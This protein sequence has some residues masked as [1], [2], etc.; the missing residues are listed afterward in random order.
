MRHPRRAARRGPRAADRHA[1]RRAG[2][3]LG[4]RPVPAPGAQIAYGPPAETLTNAVLEGTYGEEIVVLDCGHRAVAIQHHS[5]RS[6]TH[7]LM[8]ILRS[9]LLQR[10]LLEVVIVGATCGALGVWLLH[11]RHT[12]AAESLAHAMLPGLVLAALAGAP[13]LL[14]AA[15]GV[16]VAAALIALAARDTPRRRR[17][18][19]RRDGDDGVRPRRRARARAR[20][21]GPPRRAAVRRPARRRAPPTSSSP[22]ALAARR[23]ARARAP[24]T[25]RS[26]V[27]VFDPLAAP[28]LGVRP[29]RVELALLALLALAVVAAVQ[30]LGNLLVLA[31]IVAPA[32][33][34]IRARPDGRRRRSRSPPGS[35]RW[36]ACSGSCASAELDIAAGASV[37]LAAIALWVVAALL[38]PA[39]RAG[40]GPRRSLVET[41]GRLTVRD[42][43]RRRRGRRPPASARPRSPPVPRQR[44]TARSPPATHHH[45]A[46]QLGLGEPGDDRVVAAHELDEE[47][48]GARQ[49]QVAGEQHARA[50]RVARAPQAPR[51]EAHRERLVDRRRVHD[52]GRRHD[53]VGIGHRP[54]AGRSACRSRRRRRSGSRS[55]RPRSRARAPARTCRAASRLNIPRRRAHSRTPA[56]PPSRPPNQTSP[57]PP[58]M[59]PRTSPRTSSRLPRIQYSRAPSRPPM[60]AAKTIS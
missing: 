46:Q 53:A 13:L 24:G 25:A 30:G 34:A 15:G 10:A 39:A 14:G 32:A 37:A 57:E 54:R 42:A 28:S 23:R 12:Y 5:H 58:K 59:P 43:G 36:R 6:T 1:R 3:P 22:A 55:A 50:A 8:E 60:S 49:H 18:R 56:A 7:D 47:A 2:P 44:R 11:L 29:G 48:L 9:G 21:A 31:L 35:A 40:G 38:R 51:D 16:L 26:R 33:A 27:A 4:S 17:D 52:L 20:R 45:E 19:R 41:L